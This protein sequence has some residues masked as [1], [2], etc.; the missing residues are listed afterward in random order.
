M[1]V[2]GLPADNAAP[3]GVQVQKDFFS[4]SQWNFLQDITHATLCADMQDIA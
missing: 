2:P 4:M 3:F 1:L